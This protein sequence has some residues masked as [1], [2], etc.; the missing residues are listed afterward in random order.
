MLLPI[1]FLTHHLCHKHQHLGHHHLLHIHQGIHDNQRNLIPCTKICVHIR[2]KKSKATIA[3]TSRFF[4][5]IAW[6]L[7]SHTVDLAKHEESAEK[8]KAMATKIKIPTK[9]DYKNVPKQY[10]SGRPLLTFEKQRK[11]PTGIKRLHDWYMR[12]SSV[13]IDVISVHIPDHAFIGSD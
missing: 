2:E 4:K 13:G 10:V 6:D 8:A 3:G 7:T 9:A 12:A 11:V 5:G 1:L